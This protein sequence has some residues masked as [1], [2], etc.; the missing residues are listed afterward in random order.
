ME[1][2]RPRETAPV[3]SPRQPM[4]RARSPGQISRKGSSKQGMRTVVS[5]SA[6]SRISLSPADPLV[7]PVCPASSLPSPR[8]KRSSFSPLGTTRVKVP[9]FFPAT[10]LTLPHHWARYSPFFSWICPRPPLG[11]SQGRTE[12]LVSLRADL[13]RLSQTRAE[14][15]TSPGSG[16]SKIRLSPS[17][18]DP[19]QLRRI[20]RIPA[21][22]RPWAWARSRSLPGPWTKTP[23][24]VTSSASNWSSGR[25]SAGSLSSHRSSRRLPSGAVSTT[26]RGIRL[27]SGKA[28]ASSRGGVQRISSRVVFSAMTPSRSPQR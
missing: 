6:A 16:R 17:P 18:A 1:T 8:G 4:P 3:R 14:T 5:L 28:S 13:P 23:R 15:V 11:G 26:V 27:F 20:F 24:P 25:I 9:W 22:Y 12:R 10:S 7:T 2:G 19:P 21:P